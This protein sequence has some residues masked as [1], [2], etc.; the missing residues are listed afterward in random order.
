MVWWQR[1]QVISILLR[2]YSIAPLRGL[3]QLR[4]HY[5]LSGSHGLF[6]RHVSRIQQNGVRSPLQGRIGA[7]A[8]PLVAGAKV[9]KHLIRLHG[10]CGSEL[11][12]AP[13][14]P[15]LWSGVKEDFDLGMV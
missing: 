13:Q 10:R 15:H 5:V 14:T 2:A 6:Q 1:V 4:R 9:A 3:L 7:V 12:E 8:V 11:I